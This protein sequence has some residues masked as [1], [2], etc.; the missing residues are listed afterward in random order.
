MD[1][2]K[3]IL[4]ILG[5]IG[6]IFTYWFFLMK[7]DQVVSVKDEIEIVVEGG[8][9]PDSISIPKGKTSRLIFLRRD[10]SACLEEVVLGDFKIRRQLPLNQ[11]VTIELTP[12][13]IG[14]FKY[15]CGMGM[16]HGK[17]I[18]TN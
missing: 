18:V 10:P 5:G 14:E 4:T 1:T 11:K 7:K 13:Q 15:S 8:Y 16:Y 3:I 2:D 12:Q 6:I 9:S 17:I